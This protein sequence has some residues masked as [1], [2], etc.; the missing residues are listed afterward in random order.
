MNATLL[1]LR[2]EVRWALGDALVMAWRNMLRYRR[3]P[4]LLVF[5][6]IQPVMFVL[7]FAFV[8]GGA[9]QTGS[10]NYIDYLLPGI[11]VQTVIFGAMQTGIGLAEDLAGGLVDRY[12]SLPMAR[13]AVIAG[14]ILADTARNVFV[15]ALMLAVG[16]AIGFRFHTD[17]GRALAVVVV[18]VLFG[19]AFS[20]VSACI[21][22][23]V[24][25]VET[26]EVAGFIW[27]FP[28]TF[29]SSTFVPVQS[30]PAWLQTVATHNP[31]TIVVDLLRAL[32]QGGPVA[33]PLWQTAAWAAGIV[34][35]F[36]PI[37]I[38]LYRRPS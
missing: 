28:L 6:T 31:V 24:K 37:A 13:S 18:A 10:A 11:F 2:T 5:S 25:D 32:S 16:H 36:A 35:V 30:M 22:V 8:F 14:R 29:L 15:V 38:A 33:D 17:V 21:G 27:V 9:I 26:A 4:E 34:A 12:R 20:W 1:A 7:L 3:S 23:A 19:H